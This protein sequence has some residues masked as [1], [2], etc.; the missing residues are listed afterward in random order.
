MCTDIKIAG[1]IKSSFIDYPGTVSTVLFLSGC[2]LRCPFCHNPAIVLD[3]LPRIPF[4]KIQSH[5]L[6]RKGIIDGVVISGGE[7]TIYKTLPDLVNELHSIGVRVKIDTNGLEPE[8]VEACSADYLAMD[9]KAV[10]SK[11]GLLGAGYYDVEQRLKESIKL[12]EKMGTKGEIRIPVVPGVV[13]E[14]DVG[15][16][17]GLLRDVDK[18]Y[19]QPLKNS[20]EL[21]DSSLNGIKGF[22]PETLMRWREQFRQTSV[23]CFIRGLES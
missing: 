16:L 10:P 14:E 3:E 6:I 4:H 20:V 15:E 12:V 5:L 18:V 7:P 11:Y 8:V 9:L 23:N 19:L 22:S 13:D 21:L 1:W 17:I 2:N